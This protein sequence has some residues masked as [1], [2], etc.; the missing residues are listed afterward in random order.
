MWGMRRAALPATTPLAGRL[1]LVRHGRTEWSENGRHT[2]VTDLPLLPEG[3]EDGRGLGRRLE[4]FDIAV[5]LTSPRQRAR[6]TAELAGFGTAEVDEDLV[7]WDYGGYEGRTTPQI[8]EEVGYDWTVFE[9]GVV[10]GQTPGETVEEVAARAS[11]VIARVLPTLAERDAVLFGHGHALRVL[12]ATFLRREPR[13]G[14][15]LVLDAGALCV[16]GERREQPVI[17]LWNG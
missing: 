8:R 7:E 3:E 14:A 9:H 13:F 17:R 10:P 4:E 12:A 1:I 11:R 6:R 15:H 5:A 2:G 16:L